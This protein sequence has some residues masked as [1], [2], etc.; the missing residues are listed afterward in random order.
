MILTSLCKTM[1]P[2]GIQAN[3]DVNVLTKIIH[4]STFLKKKKNLVVEDMINILYEL[5]KDL[6]QIEIYTSSKCHH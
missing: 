2:K 4:L 6:M 1:L 3:L 5:I